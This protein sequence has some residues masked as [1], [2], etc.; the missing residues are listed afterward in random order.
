[1]SDS[2]DAISAWESLYRAQ[3]AVLRDLLAEFP[4]HGISFT[5]Y[6]VIFNLYRQPG[7][8]LRIRDLNTHL[9]LTQP[10]VSRLLDRLAARGIVEKKRDPADARGTIVSLTQAGIDVFR[11]V[12]TAHAES[13]V[14]RMAPLSPEELAQLSA[15]TTKLREGATHRSVRADV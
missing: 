2:T 5:E 10:S 9:L 14:A 3:V 8:A 6:D 11:K 13:I 7:H 1:M 12:G 4:D 15:L